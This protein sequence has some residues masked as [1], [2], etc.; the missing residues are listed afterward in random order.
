MKSFI[1]ALSGDTICLVFS[2][3][4]KEVQG[5]TLNHVFPSKGKKEKVMKD[6]S[7]SGNNDTMCLTLNQK[8]IGYRG[9]WYYN[10]PSGDEYVYKYSGGLGTYCAKHRPFAVYRPEVDK[11]FFCYGGT[12]LDAYLKHTYPVLHFHISAWKNC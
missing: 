1:L 5:D 10:Q 9:I 3:D 4:G 8:D 7:A 11:T 6:K 12:P 2:S